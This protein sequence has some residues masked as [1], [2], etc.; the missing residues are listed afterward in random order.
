MDTSIEQLKNILKIQC[1][2]DNTKYHEIITF[3]KN[4][5]ILNETTLI[6]PGNINGVARINIDNISRLAVP[7]YNKQYSESRIIGRGGFGDVFISKYYLDRK[8][9]AIKKIPIYEEDLPNIENY[10]S[11]ILIL[12]HLDHKNIVRYYTSWIETPHRNIDNLDDSNNLETA[13]LPIEYSKFNEISLSTTINSDS[14]E[15]AVID[16]YIQMELCKHFNLGDIIPSLTS[17]DALNIIK[18]IIQGVKYLHSKNIIHRDI[19]PKNILFSLE[20]NTVKLADFGLS[21]LE[22]SD[23][24]PTTPAGTYLYID[25]HGE[26]NSKTYDIYSLGVVITELVC[27]F[28]T[29]M[30]RIEQL[31]KMKNG[32]IPENQEKNI[33][34]IISKCICS[35]VKERYTI[36]ELEEV[37]NNIMS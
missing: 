4:K 2:E 14:G 21:C 13:L 17:V 19:K 10:L 20:S 18:E 25:P 34:N 30:E 5:N 35:D 3:L 6:K 15:D 37:I 11:E 36:I 28:K 8:I 12:S 31:K 26:Y 24:R 1:G 33:K 23:K 32:V 22:N 27:K 29:R 16:L 7:R 9:Y